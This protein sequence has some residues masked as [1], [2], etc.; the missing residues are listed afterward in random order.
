MSAKKHKR[1]HESAAAGEPTK[2]SDELIAALRSCLERPTAL[3]SEH[4]RTLQPLGLVRPLRTD[5]YLYRATKL[6]RWAMT[7]DGQ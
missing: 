7:G 2:L 3:S 1:T 4:A 5:P 6:A